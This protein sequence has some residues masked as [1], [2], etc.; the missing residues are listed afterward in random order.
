MVK[1]GERAQEWEVCKVASL[2]AC[3]WCK[4][5]IAEILSHLP[6]CVI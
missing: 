2:G 5:H 4:E 1:A 6:S 3:G